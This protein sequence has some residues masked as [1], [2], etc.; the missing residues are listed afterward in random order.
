MEQIVSFQGRAER[1]ATIGAILVDAGRLSPEDALRVVQLQQQKRIKFGEAALELG[2]A[3]EADIQFA[4]SQQF[5]Y[6]YFDQ[7]GA[8]A[9]SV[10]AAYQPFSAAMEA[11]RALRSQLLLRWFEPAEGGRCLAVVSPGGGD[12]RSWLVANLAVLFSQ[13]GERTL[14]IDADLRQ[15]CQHQLFGIE[16]RHGLSGYLAG[17]DGNEAIARIPGLTNL[18]LLAAGVVPPNP[19]ELLARPAFAQLLEQQCRQFDV[20]LI[21]TPAANFADAQLIAARAG[22]ALL[23]GR[24]HHSSVAELRQCSQTLLAA[25]VT[26]VGSV[27]NEY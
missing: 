11:L 3:S 16:G 23:L 25:G 20:V 12:G 18:S 6:A 22:G 19:Q 17:H 26:L 2:V 24:R 4:M 10:V 8:V 21:D 27:L 13:L 1:R 14:L 9:T 15:P 7:P 5:A